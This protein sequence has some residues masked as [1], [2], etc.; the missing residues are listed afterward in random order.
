MRK[1]LLL[2]LMFLNLSVL[3]SWS[4]ENVIIDRIT[5]AEAEELDIQIPDDVPP[6]FHSVEIEVYDDGGTLSVQEIVFCKNL[7]GE[8]R[9]DNECPDVTELWAYEDLIKIKERE[10]LPAYSPAQEPERSKDLAVAAFAA[11]AALT[12]VGAAKEK[13][14]RDS[15]DQPEGEDKEQEDLASVDS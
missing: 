9:W 1:F 10:N 5:A 8:V 15:E 14:S 3:P 13:E 11:L 2:V 12:V 7:T 4:A 6:G